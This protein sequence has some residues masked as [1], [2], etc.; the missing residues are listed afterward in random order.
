MARVTIDTRPIRDLAGD[1]ILAGSTYESLL[2]ARERKPDIPVIP[3]RTADFAFVRYIGHP[4]MEV[5]RPLLDEWGMYFASQI[6]E[7][8]EVYVF[9]HSPDNQLAPELCREIH[10]LVAGQAEIDPLPWDAISGDPP[11]QGRL[12]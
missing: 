6:K 7:G 8:A 1:A 12:F 4:H 3:K 9:C 11:A 2:E 10:R 5:N